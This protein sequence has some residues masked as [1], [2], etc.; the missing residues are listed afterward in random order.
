MRERASVQSSY[1]SS[2]SSSNNSPAYSVSNSSVSS[3]AASTPVRPTVLYSN[4]NHSSSSGSSISI[5]ITSETQLLSE[6]PPTPIATTTVAVAAEQL[7]AQT[8][9]STIVIPV[10][11]PP[12]LPI[13]LP[14]YYG[15]ERIWKDR[16]VRFSCR[17]TLFKQTIWQTE[18]LELNSRP[19]KGAWINIIAYSTLIYTIYLENCL[20]IEIQTIPTITKVS[21]LR[22]LFNK[23]NN[24]HSFLKL[25]FGNNKKKLK[26]WKNAIIQHINN[27]K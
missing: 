1:G 20:P 14:P 21:E 16:K 12:P 7:P 6:S 23:P 9:T 3:S 15:P 4:H 24:K 22:L 11:P 8:E 10:P 19:Q 2:N 26:A 13:Q 27:G 18:T 5:P 25:S 17:K